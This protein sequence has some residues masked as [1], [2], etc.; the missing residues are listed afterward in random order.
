MDGVLPPPHALSEGLEP[1][2]GTPGMASPKGRQAVQLQGALSG[3][4]AALLAVYPV[5]LWKKPS[6]GL[7]SSK[8]KKTISPG[9]GPKP[10]HPRRVSL[11]AAP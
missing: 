5:P 7:S 11:T 6:P 3:A 4:R 2:P 10:P 1:G 9:T 8:I